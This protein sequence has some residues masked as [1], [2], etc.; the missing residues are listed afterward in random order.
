M[1]ASE[2]AARPNAMVTKISLV[3]QIVVAY[4]HQRAWRCKRSSADVLFVLALAAPGRVGCGVQSCIPIRVSRWL[5]GSVGRLS[6]PLEVAARQAGAVEKP[7]ACPALKHRP[8]RQR[9]DSAG[10][11]VHDL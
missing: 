9:A 6:V 2:C 3:F 8:E 5:I 11:C 4:S 10:R 1:S 7:G